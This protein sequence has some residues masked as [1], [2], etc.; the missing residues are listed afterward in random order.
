MNAHP[1]PAED[2]KGLNSQKTKISETTSSIRKIS[3]PQ[4]CLG[5]FMS[6]FAWAENPTGGQSP[7]GVYIGLSGSLYIFKS[8]YGAIHCMVGNQRIMWRNANGRWRNTRHDNLI[9]YEI[10][11]ERLLINRTFADG[12]SS[13]DHYPLA[14]LTKHAP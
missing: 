7:M 1:R 12:S 10:L 3:A 9:R 4:I 13:T 2:I 8:G 11:G 14:L 6:E 5:A